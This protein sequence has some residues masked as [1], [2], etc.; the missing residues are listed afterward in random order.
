MG[1]DG[2][3]EDIGR[4]VEQPAT[5]QREALGGRGRAADRGVL[6]FFGHRDR[7]RPVTGGQCHPHEV[8]S[9]GA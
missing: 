6:E 3:D 9:H 5:A 8:G 1:S 7:L 4:V 2:L